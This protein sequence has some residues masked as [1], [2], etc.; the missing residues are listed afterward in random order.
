MINQFN[1]AQLSDA[2][3]HRLMLGCLLVVDEDGEQPITG[4]AEE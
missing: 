4:W 3:D 1:A 2:E